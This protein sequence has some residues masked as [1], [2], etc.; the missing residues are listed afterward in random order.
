MAANASHSGGEEEN[1]SHFS[2]EGEE[3]ALLALTRQYQ[4]SFYAGQRQ[5]TTLQ[6]EKN[7]AENLWERYL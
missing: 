7:D 5:R 6:R 4:E 3:N 1:L 2:F